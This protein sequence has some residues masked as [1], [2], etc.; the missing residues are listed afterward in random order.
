MVDSG[1]VH[2]FDRPMPC[3]RCD[4]LRLTAD[5]YLKPCLFSDN[6]IKVDMDDIKGA[7]LKSIGDKPLEGSSCCN[8]SMYQIG[9]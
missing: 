4:R 7:I 8:R 1:Q 5:G 3:N 6:E 9:G 2:S